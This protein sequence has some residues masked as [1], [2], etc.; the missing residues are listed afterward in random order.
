MPAKKLRVKPWE[1]ACT[2]LHPLT[3]QHVVPDRSLYYTP[4]DPLVRA[5]G[6]LFATDEEIKAYY[7]GEMTPVTEV[8]LDPPKRGRRA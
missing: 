4:D 5:H 2:I 3:E 1:G 6:W 7:D 8:K